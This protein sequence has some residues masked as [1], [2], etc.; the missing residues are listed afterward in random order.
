M[1][2][3]GK[4]YDEIISKLEKLCRKKYLGGILSGVVAIVLITIIAF[5][6][7]T[8]FE[9]I[10]HLNSTPRTV[11]FF[12]G[13]LIAAAVFIYLLFLPLLRYFKLLRNE[14]YFQVAK[15]V[16][17]HFPDVK[18]DLL[19]SMQLVSTEIGDK[20]YSHSLID[21][22]F[23]KVYYRTKN[24]KFESIINFKNV[25]NKFLRT[26]VIGIVVLLLFLFLPGL[27]LSIHLQVIRNAIY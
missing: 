10:A 21:A 6:L 13:L 24:L 5:T 11:L 7:F 4:Y 1:G 16:G 9:L 3:N 8:L 2:T 20:Y 25:W 26:A 23:K 12:V 22:A 27:L 18:D 19:N 17:D 15:N 14:S